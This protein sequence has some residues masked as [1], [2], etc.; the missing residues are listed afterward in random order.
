MC[1]FFFLVCGGKR[2]GANMPIS[3]RTVCVHIIGAANGNY[4]AVFFPLP[5]F[6]VVV[7]EFE[8]T[9]RGGG[10]FSESAPTP[11]PPPP[12]PQRRRPHIIILE[13]TCLD[14]PP[15]ENE[16]GR[17]REKKIRSFIAPVSPYSST[18]GSRAAETEGGSSQENCSKQAPPLPLSVETL[19]SSE[20]LHLQ[21]SCH[22]LILCAQRLRCP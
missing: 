1:R 19:F 17:E 10:K 18:Y 11:S 13:Q 6:R 16:E 4:C 12:P 22:A 20:P 2:F 3:V 9:K 8:Y 15:T 14:P 7:S 5:L 21:Q